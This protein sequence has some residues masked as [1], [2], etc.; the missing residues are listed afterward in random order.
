MM[1]LQ[2][3]AQALGRNSYYQDTAHPAP[4][5]PP[6]TGSVRADVCI[7]GAGLAGLSAALELA[8]R[9]M[10]VVVLEAVRVGWGA[11][12]RNGG[13]ALAGYASDMGPFEQ[14]IGLAAARTAWD[15]SRE[16]VRLMRKRIAEHAIDCGWNAG[17]LSVAVT[18][19]K[20]R[21]LRQ[22]ADTM[23]ERYGASHLQW[24]D[25]EATR[26]QVASERYCAGVMDPE[27]GHLHPLNY[28]LGLARAAVDLGVVIHEDSE[29]RGV[30]SGSASGQAGGFGRGGRRDAAA[31]L[32]VRT[33]GGGRA[34]V[35]TAQGEVRCDAVLLAGNANLGAVAPQLARRIMPVGTYIMATEPLGRARAERLIPSRAA[36]CDTQFVLDYYRLSGDDRLLF[37]GRVSYSTVSPQD[38]PATMRR[39]MLRV[40]PQLGD[41]AVTHAW[42]GFVDITM[43]RA[44]DFGRLAPDIYYLQGFSGHG[45]ALTGLAGQLAAEAIA[46]QAERFD[47]F[48]RLQHRPFPG[49]DLLRT[50]ALVLGMLWYRLRDLF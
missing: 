4:A 34:C 42:G 11:S 31:P 20:A 14:Q 15:M 5:H 48:A 2:A 24:L 3:Q 19:K 47:L 45:L 49:G 13:Q 7:V 23:Q 17:A 1:R 18:P 10:K 6:L 25:A 9:G 26:A 38:L 33:D 32:D 22:W 16:A 36:V 43:N 44:P 41:V 29:V 30:A 39:G 35:R 28:T 8:R 37:G 50:P 12:G 27:G 21:A 40:F 46:G